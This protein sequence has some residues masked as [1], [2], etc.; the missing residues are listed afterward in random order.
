MFSSG[1]VFLRDRGWI[2]DDQ[3]NVQNAIKYQYNK[4]KRNNT[5]LE[6]DTF[7]TLAFFLGLRRLR[8]A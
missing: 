2:V 4:I 6:F 7:Q 5:Y 1:I 3:L 8:S